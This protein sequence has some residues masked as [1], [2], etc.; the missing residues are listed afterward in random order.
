M[1]ELPE[2]ET[3]RRVLEPQLG[4]EIIKDV[5]VGKPQIIAGMDAVEFARA[6]QGRKITGMG[7]RGKFLSLILDNGDRVV[8]HLRM[9]GSLLVTPADFEAEKHTHVVIRLE[10]GRQIRFIDQRR[11][12]RFWL[13]RNGEEDT[14][15]GI[16]KLGIEPFDKRLTPAYLKERLYK[17]KKPIKECLLDQ[18]LVAGIGNIYGDEILFRVRIA[19]E[20][21]ACDLKETEWKRL[22]KE[23]PLALQYYIEKN[24][25]SPEDYLAGKGGDYRN[26][27][28]L[29]VYGHAGEPCPV[30]GKPLK[31]SVIG[32]RSSVSCPKCQK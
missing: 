7:R 5:Q 10:S 24:E 3:V 32:G 4:G 28:F 20:K 26:T 25:I 31:R 29:Q 2:V 1:P 21:K 14:I 27:P 30:C 23:I 19:P 18:T 6:L 8:L 15:S 11:F 22:A 9:T 12:G 16:H 17:R 13:I